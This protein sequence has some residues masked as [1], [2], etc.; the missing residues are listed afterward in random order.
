M[1]ERAR[2]EFRIKNSEFRIAWCRVFQFCILHS[3]FCIA[4][5][6]QEP[7]PLPTGVEARPINEAAA[8][9]AAT[10]SSNVLRWKTKPRTTVSDNPAAEVTSQPISDNSAVP[11]R[12]GWNITRIDPGVK[13]AQHTSA[14]PFSDP[15]G[16]RKVEGTLRVP[17][18][19]NGTR[20]VPTT[21]TDGPSLM[22]QPTQAESRVEE[23]PPP[24]T[25]SPAVVGPN[26]TMRSADLPPPMINV[27]QRPSAPSG[28]PPDLPLSTDPPC[29]RK[30]QD[31]NC[32]KLEAD[33]HAF[34]NRLLSDSIRNISLDITPPFKHDPNVTEDEARG[35][36]LSRQGVR[37]WRNRRG[38]VVATG[39]LVD[40]EHNS[41]VLVDANGASAGR[42]RIDELGEDELC[43]LSAMWDL[44][45]ECPL[46]GIR[47]ASRQWLATAF[48]YH[49]SALCHKPLYF[50]EVQLERYG[51]TAGPFRQP[52]ISGAHFMISLLALPYQMGMHP[53]NECVYPLG[54]YRP[55]NCAPW[56]IPPIPLSLEGAKLEIAAALGMI[57]LI[58]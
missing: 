48:E 16:D 36:K 24:R 35:D 50:E 14:D 3:A 42:V 21:N 9:E 38:A 52:I 5:F 28:A 19:Q 11:M 49:A 12:A 43:Y 58:P 31:R 18:Q 57:Y 56:M 33:C 39:Q 2:T 34:R 22:L 6:A 4:A 27:A 25:L 10:D 54:Y 32:C 13:P 29:D 55:G 45:S 44:P 37:Q 15:F 8:A 53:P 17:S 7:L 20:S 23:L 46:G 26:N 40:V 1:K 51:H 47:S 41:L 30:Y